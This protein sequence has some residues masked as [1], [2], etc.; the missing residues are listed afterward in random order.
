MAAVQRPGNP[1]RD[2]RKGSLIC[3]KSRN[4]TFVTRS[5]ARGGKILRPGETVS[6]VQLA[7]V[8]CV[9]V[10]TILTCTLS[11]PP[12]WLY[13][14]ELR[15]C[16]KTPFTAATKRSRQ[17]SQSCKSATVV[18]TTKLP[19]YDRHYLTSLF[20]PL[21]MREWMRIPAVSTRLRYCCIRTSGGG[22]D[23]GRWARL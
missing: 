21:T 12:D 8:Q 13:L 9:G 18:H 4:P 15:L 11:V 23:D 3:F 10:F 20:S 5:L 16:A 2:V 6:V 14:R 1:K 7:L 22:P 17:I 19:K